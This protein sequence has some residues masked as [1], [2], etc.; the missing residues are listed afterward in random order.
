M[1][2]HPLIVASGVSEVRRERCR[3][4]WL[5]EEEERTW[6]LKAACEDGELASGRAPCPL[7]PGPQILGAEL[8]IVGDIGPGSA[9]L[10]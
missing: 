6:P 2:N 7:C 10:I 3:D 5:G 8:P 1:T 9:V 4:W